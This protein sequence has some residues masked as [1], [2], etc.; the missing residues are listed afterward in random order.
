MAFPFPSLKHILRPGSRSANWVWCWCWF[1]YPDSSLPGFHIKII[2][3]RFHPW[4]Q[5]YLSEMRNTLQ[6]LLLH[7]AFYHNLITNLFIHC[8]SEIENYFSACATSSSKK[9]KAPIAP[10]E[11]KNAPNSHPSPLASTGY[12]NNWKWSSTI[13]HFWAI[14]L[15]CTIS[16]HYNIKHHRRKVCKTLTKIILPINIQIQHRW[17]LPWQPLATVISSQRPLLARWYRKSES[18]TNSSKEIKMIFA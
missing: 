4:R 3:I 10:K 18:E 12:D 14:P 7:W 16:Q 2:K 6:P 8:K 9:I 5:I 1:S 11:M 15:F 13:F 17:W